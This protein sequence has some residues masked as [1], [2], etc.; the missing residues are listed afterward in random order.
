M[1][2]AGFVTCLSLCKISLQQEAKLSIPF[3]GGIHVN[4]N[5]KTLANYDFY[6]VESVTEHVAL[7]QLIQISIYKGEP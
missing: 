5:K 4:N 1:E 3:K 2:D 7:W 6:L